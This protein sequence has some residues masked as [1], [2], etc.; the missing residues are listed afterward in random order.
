MVWCGQLRLAVWRQK[1]NRGYRR[2]YNSGYLEHLTCTGPKRFY[3]IFH[4]RVFK[5]GCIRHMHTCLHS[6]MRACTDTHTHGYACRHTRT[7]A[8]MH[9]RMHA[10]TCTHTCTHTHTNIDMHAY[11]HM[12]AHVHAHTHTELYIRAVSMNI[13][14]AGSLSLAGTSGLKL[15]VCWAVACAFHVVVWHKLWHRVKAGCSSALLLRDLGFC[16]AMSRS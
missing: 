2:Y 3:T 6:C 12:H 5:I 11:T 16:W 7:D 9:A 1:K 4:V 15:I 14:I 8:C 10:R 13:L